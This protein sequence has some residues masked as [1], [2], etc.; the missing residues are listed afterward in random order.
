MSFFPQGLILMF[1]F[2]IVV[3]IVSGIKIKNE[4]NNNENL[5]VDNAINALNIATKEANNAI[6]ELDKISKSVFLEMENKYQEILYLY[7]LME[8]KKNEP[9]NI[10]EQEKI[11]PKKVN[12]KSNEIK[13][14]HLDGLGIFEIAKKLNMGIGEV[15][16]IIELGKDR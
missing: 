14:L 2:G 10:Q 16:L 8:D 12:V 7:Y 13:K 6:N 9:E 11:K 15:K 4:E 5:Q 3:V 1:L